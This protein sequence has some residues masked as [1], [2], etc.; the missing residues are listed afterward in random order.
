MRRADPSVRSS[1]VAYLEGAP[2]EVW[3]TISDVADYRRWWPWLH[4]LDAQSLAA[5]QTWRCRVKPPLPYSVAFSIHV[6]EVVVEQLVV[7]SLTGDIRGTARLEIRPARTG[8]EIRLTATLTPANRLLA[9]MTTWFA[10]VARFGHD[11]IISDG[12]RQFAA[13]TGRRLDGP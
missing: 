10:P 4:E 6:E 2:G 12:F 1:H 13:A 9:L 5:G 8:T 11:R 3:A 7:A